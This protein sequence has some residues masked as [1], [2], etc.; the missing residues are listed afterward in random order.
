MRIGELIKEL[1][2]FD[3][4]EE[5]L[6]KMENHIFKDDVRGVVGIEVHRVTSDEPGRHKNYGKKHVTLVQS[7]IVGTVEDGYS[8][9]IEKVQNYCAMKG[10]ATEE[11]VDMALDFFTCDN[12]LCEATRRSIKEQFLND[13]C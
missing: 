8:F 13:R 7:D 12:T 10:G 9:I 5:I 6:V 1:E 4:D 3:K 2:K 11:N